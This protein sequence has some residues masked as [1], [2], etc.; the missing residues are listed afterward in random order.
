MQAPMLKSYVFN[1]RVFSR[2]ATKTRRSQLIM[3]VSETAKRNASSLPFAFPKF[4]RSRK[5]SK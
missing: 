4:V 3:P 1:P 5:Q 2:P